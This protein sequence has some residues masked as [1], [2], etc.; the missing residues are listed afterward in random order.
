MMHD[1]GPSL[2]LPS[3]LVADEQSGLF[4]NTE[5]GRTL[6]ARRPGRLETETLDARRPVFA[7]QLGGHFMGAYVLGLYH[8]KHTSPP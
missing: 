6:P 7:H 8:K 1:E 3:R 5:D 4:E 2:L